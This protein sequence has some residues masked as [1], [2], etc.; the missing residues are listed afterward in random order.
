MNP[1]PFPDGRGYP[2]RLRRTGALLGHLACAIPAERA[3]L[4]FYLTE[5]IPVRPPPLDKAPPPA[6]TFRLVWDWERSCLWADGT[7]FL[8]L[9]GATPA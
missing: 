7:E 9:N 5:P 6:R 3:W 1:I 4:E 2:V 8:R